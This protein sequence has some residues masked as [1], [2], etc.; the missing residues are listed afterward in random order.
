MVR[1][2]EA[3]TRRTRFFRRCVAETVDVPECGAGCAF[4][5]SPAATKAS[6]RRSLQSGRSIVMQLRCETLNFSSDRIQTRY[7]HETATQGRNAF[8]RL[9]TIL[10]SCSKLVNQK[11]L[12]QLRNFKPAVKCLVTLHQTPIHESAV[13]GPSNRPKGYSAGFGDVV[14]FPAL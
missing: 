5:R 7:P 6:G 8:E 3:L 4:D 12:H 14:L 1:A 11:I 13:Q 9:L 2:V 10:S